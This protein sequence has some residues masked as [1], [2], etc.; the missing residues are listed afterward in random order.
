MLT[1]TLPSVFPTHKTILL[2]QVAKSQKH[3]QSIKKMQTD[4]FNGKMFHA[5]DIGDVGL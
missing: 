4:L 2:I 5:T 1:Q 3:K